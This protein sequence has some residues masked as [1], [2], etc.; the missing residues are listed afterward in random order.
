MTGVDADPAVTRTRSA[1]Q[2]DRALG[3]DLARGR[4]VDRL[5][6]TALLLGGVIMLLPFA[7]M[8]STSWRLAK[9]SFSLPPSGGPRP[10]TW[11]TTGKS[12]RTSPS[13][14]SW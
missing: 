4:A 12:S 11:R 14:P 9:D 8:F 3:A 5:I 10:G 6:V 13:S 1:G 2:A 7:W